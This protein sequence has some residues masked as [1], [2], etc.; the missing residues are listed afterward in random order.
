MSAIARVFLPELL[1][2]I[3]EFTELEPYRDRNLNSWRRN[4]AHS[5]QSATASTF[6]L[7]VNQR[8]Y[9]ATL[10]AEAQHL[11]NHAAEQRAHMLNA[12]STGAEPSPSWL[13]VSLY[14]MSLYAAMSWT[15]VANAAIVYLDRDAINEYGGA[16]LKMPAAGAFELQSHL[17]PATSISYATF[18]KCSSSHFHEAVWVA[19]H[20]LAGQATSKIGAMS[21]NRKPTDDELVALRGLSLF[22]G[23]QFRNPL[24]WQSKLRNGVN[25]RPGYS[26]RSVV[27]HNF[28]RVAARLSK[29]RLVDIAEVVA[30]GERAKASLHGVVDPFDA[31]DSCID[32]LVSQTLFLE[33][34]TESALIELCNHHELSSSAFRAR[35]SYRRATRRHTSVIDIPGDG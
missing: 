18:K 23:Y 32:L 2:V 13:L 16:G 5:L 4:G 12:L 9:G 11:L 27:K 34:S 25:Y 33:E 21:A 8:E 35:G 29:P 22:Q 10:F 28:L 14:Y 15:R 24:V 7:Q 19:V 3:P 20:K 30:N 31:V 17:D 26:Y 6:V 1:D